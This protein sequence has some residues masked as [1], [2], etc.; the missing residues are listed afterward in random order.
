MFDDHLLV[1]K[2]TGKPMP[3]WGVAMA[4][5]KKN[6]NETDLVL[7]PRVAK[8]VSPGLPG[9]PAP[10]ATKGFVGLLHLVGKASKPT[11]MGEVLSEKV[12]G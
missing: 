12:S 2:P 3:F 7:H 4:P 11:N 5:Y 1:P 9:R 6:K 10:W 8:A